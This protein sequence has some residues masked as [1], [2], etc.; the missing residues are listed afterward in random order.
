VNV[1]TG[2]P[3]VDVEMPEPTVRFVRPEPNIRIEQ[4]QPNVEVSS[5]EPQVNIDQAE[6]ADVALEQAEADVDL[7][8]SGD[9]DIEVTQ[10]EPQVEVDPAE[11]ADVEI[12]QAEA[13]VNVEQDG[14]GQQQQGRQEIDANLAN[15][16]PTGLIGLEVMT[17]GDEMIGEIQRVVIDDEDRLAVVV[18]AGD[19]VDAED[20]HVAI[21]A[22]RLRVEQGDIYVAN[23]T[24][25][26]IADMPAYQGEAQDLQGSVRLRDQQGSQQN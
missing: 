24:R 14:G 13:Q 26:D 4:G 16:T 12:E 17:D 23:L 5:A 1:E 15:M 9:A 21:M 7:E 19:M 20:H 18:D 6:D 22:E 10:G 3:M 25:Q 11:E 8:Q 2:E